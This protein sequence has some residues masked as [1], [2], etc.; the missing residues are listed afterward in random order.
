MTAQPHGVE[1]DSLTSGMV[2]PPDVTLRPGRSAARKIVEALPADSA[3][4]SRVGWRVTCTFS[5]TTQWVE[6]EHVIQAD[7][8]TGLERPKTDDDTPYRS[9]QA[10]FGSAKDEF[11]EDGTESQFARE[12]KVLI[13]KHRR[14]ALEAISHL[15]LFT[16]TGHHVANEALSTLGTVSE[17]TTYEYRRWLLEQSLGAPSAVV[18]DGAVI[19]LAWLDD[20]HA[21]PYVQRAVQ[22]EQVAP[23]RRSMER[24]LEQLG[25][26]S[27]WHWSLE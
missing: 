11:L 6:T 17:P 23:L 21:V 8:A 2:P 16:K 14:S 3:K 7:N 15:I 9:V 5:S 18:R 4:R 27:R 12:I 1:T 24:L 13:A 22:G 20:P 25:K 26:E 19:G 10:A